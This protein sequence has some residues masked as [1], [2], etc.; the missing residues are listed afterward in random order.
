MARK[1]TRKRSVK[2]R[3]KWYESEQ[4]TLILEDEKYESPVRRS[5]TD[6]VQELEYEANVTEELPYVQQSHS[7]VAPDVN[8][9]EERPKSPL[10][11]EVYKA[12]KS[13]K[14]EPLNIYDLS[15]HAVEKR[16]QLK[17]RR[18]EMDDIHKSGIMPKL[19][20]MSENI[21]MANNIPLLL[22]KS[23]S[24]GYDP[25]E[26]VRMSLSNGTLSR[27]KIFSKIKVSQD[28]QIGGN[29]TWGFNAFVKPK[30]MSE[31]TAS[32]S[33]DSNLNEEDTTR[34]KSQV[35]PVMITI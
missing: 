16:E 34:N 4:D 10:P 8:M 30:N 19:L 23:M 33:L 20:E 14:N 11:H 24:E 35:A 7:E 13:T 25:F 3:T 1:G 6:P 2:N 22:N 21:E 5:Q 9:D 12:C 26:S 27:D 32:S 18:A 17:A 15:P 29:S 31:R 28:V